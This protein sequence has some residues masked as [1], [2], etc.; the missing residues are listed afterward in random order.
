MSAV[1]N[2]AKLQYRKALSIEVGII[3][4]LTLV[5]FLLKENVSMSFLCGG[6]VSFL[7]HC[8][9]VYWVFFRNSARDR[10]KIT[11]FYWAEGIKWLL[12]IILI[13]ISFTLIPKLHLLAFFLGYFLALCLNIALPMWLSRKST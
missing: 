2:R 9:F 1:T 8:V 11:A 12:A 13:S 7:P 4:I 6:V 5:L 10:T 3:F